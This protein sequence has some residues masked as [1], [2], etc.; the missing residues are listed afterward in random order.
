MGSSLGATFAGAEANLAI[1]LARLGHRVTYLTVVGE[2]TF[3]RVILG[4][5]GAEGVD[6]AGCHA[7]SAAHEVMFKERRDPE[8]PGVMYYRKGSAFAGVTAATF[9][10]VW[11]RAGVIF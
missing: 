7:S 6:V 9:E 4:W 10:P 1:G 3:G 2:D 8:K 11:R 5:L